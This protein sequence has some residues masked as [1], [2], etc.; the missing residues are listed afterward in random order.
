MNKHT[1]RSENDTI[2][3]K[4]KAFTE[5]FNSHLFCYEIENNRIF[6]EPKIKM[7]VLEKITVYPIPNAPKWYSG[8]TSLRGDMLTVVNMHFILGANKQ[9]TEKHLLRLEH[10]DYPPLAIAID[11]LPY[12]R[13]I[14]KLSTSSTDTS[15]HPDWVKSAV[16][17]NNKIFLFVNHSALFKAMQNNSIQ[18]PDLATVRIAIED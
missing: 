14:E 17:H 9:S 3:S 4:I 2:N 6:I 12:Q 5:S 11:N 16:E 1:T 18:Q 13:D 7:E 8:V 15:N 10:P